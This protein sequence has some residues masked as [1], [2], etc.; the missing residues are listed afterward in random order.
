MSDFVEME[1][2]INSIIFGGIGQGGLVV[3]RYGELCFELA[4][5]R[6]KYEGDE[7]TRE[8]DREVSVLVKV[9]ADSERLLLDEVQKK[10]REGCVMKVVGR[11]AGSV[12]SG[13][14][15]IVAEHV[16]FNP[17]EDE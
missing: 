9:P 14:F 1:G 6:Y 11:I 7:C 17:S 8:V 10:Y 5:W 2:S 4:S 16:E 3:S 15:H 13:G 12:R